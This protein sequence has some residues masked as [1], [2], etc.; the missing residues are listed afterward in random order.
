MM[1]A[2]PSTSIPDDARRAFVLN[3]RPLL[4]DLIELTLNHGLFVVQSAQDLAEA[5]A[6]PGDL[7]GRTSP[8]STWTT[9][10]PRRCC[11]AWA[12]RTRSDRAGRRSSA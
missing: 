9:R 7:G 6:D 2:E 4:V 11:S 10:T 5:E 12:R 3:D 8:C 1:K